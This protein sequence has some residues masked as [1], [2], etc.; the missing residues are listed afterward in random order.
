MYEDAVSTINLLT[1][2]PEEN[3]DWNRAYLRKIDYL[4]LTIGPRPNDFTPYSSRYGPIN[5]PLPDPELP[6]AWPTP[7]FLIWSNPLAH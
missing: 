6:G 4:G 1:W 5:A 2:T 3:A 7:S